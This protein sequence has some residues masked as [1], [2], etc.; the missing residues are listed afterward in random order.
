[1]GRVKG[2]ILFHK[3]SVSR[4]LGTGTAWGGGSIALNKELW[5]K[6]NALSKATNASRNSLIYMAVCDFLM[7][8]NS[9]IKS[10]FTDT[11]MQSFLKQFYTTN[12]VK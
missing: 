9:Y 2:T 10:V 4:K 3:R 6:L 11:K 8:D 1:M 7:N 12:M 5:T